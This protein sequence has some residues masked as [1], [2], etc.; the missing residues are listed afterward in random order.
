MK[1]VHLFE[2]EDQPWFP[3]VIR[4]GITNYLRFVANRL[5]FYQSVAPIIIDGLSRSGGSTIVDLASGGGGGW[6]K[7][8][9][10]L[11]GH[12]PTLRVI[13]TDRFPNADAMAALVKENSSVFSFDKNPVDARRVPP[14]LVGLRT[15]FLSLHHFN[16]EDARQILRNAVDAGQ[17][18]AVF[19]AQKRDLRHL[20]QFSMSPIAVLL[21]TPL[22]RPLRMSQLVFTYLVPVI[23][24]VT[25]WDGLVSVL[26]TYTAEELDSIIKSIPNGDSYTWEIGESSSG[27]VTIFYMLGCPK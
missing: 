13:L 19:E 6:S 17:P 4:D 26:R 2:F 24:L 3:K 27:P 21:M 1:R 9:D 15:Q 25:L 8:T 10:H 5:D 20:I 22:I 12:V 18:I 16:P 14:R 7:L 11:V 23:P